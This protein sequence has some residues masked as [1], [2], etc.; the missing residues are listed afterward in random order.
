M[1]TRLL[2][3]EPDASVLTEKQRDDFVAAGYRLW[4]ATH[5]MSSSA[6]ASRTVSE[7]TKEFAQ[8]T[9]GVILALPH[10]NAAA[11]VLS[12]INNYMHTYSIA[13]HHIDLLAIPLNHAND[14]R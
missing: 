6:N 4:D 9:S 11:S 7:L 5:K 14:R 1:T 13:S 12:D 2:Y 8:I 10:S 3:I